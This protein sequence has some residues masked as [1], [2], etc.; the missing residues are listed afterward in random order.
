MII[1]EVDD[2]QIP[3]SLDYFADSIAS[4][5]ILPDGTSCVPP[6]SNPLL[7]NQYMNFVKEG[8]IS[9]SELK[10]E[11]ELN[12]K[13]YLALKQLFESHGEKGEIN[14]DNTKSTIDKNV[15]NDKPETIINN[16]N[17][18]K[19]EIEL[20]NNKK[21]A[22]EISQKPN[23]NIE[24]TNEKEEISK[25]EEINK[26]N[27][28]SKTKENNKSEE[29]SKTEEVCKTNNNLNDNMSSINLDTIIKEDLPVTSLEKDIKEI[30]TNFNIGGSLLS[31]NSI[32]ENDS[33]G[34]Q[35]KRR[36]PLPPV[37]QSKVIDGPDQKT[38][39]K[40]VEV[41]TLPTST[42]VNEE[43]VNVLENQDS[44]QTDKSKEIKSKKNKQDSSISKLLHLPS[45]L[46]FW[47]KS[48]E[49]INKS[50]SYI[51][52]ETAC[53]L[54]IENIDSNLSDLKNSIIEAK[55]IL[56]L[57]KLSTS[58]DSINDAFEDACEIPEND[59][60]ISESGSERKSSGNLSSDSDKT[61]PNTRHEI[62]SSENR[63]EDIQHIPLK[64]DML[65]LHT[66]SKST[67][68]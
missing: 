63:N 50:S 40:S 17:N 28:I 24:N 10:G 56:K 41:I 38:S 33:S 43:N 1:E 14:D 16:E 67:D 19:T 31:L 20:S 37:N 66:E 45:K 39:D 49:N 68:V 27:E 59:N 4:D 44:Q 51:S 26:T 13:K 58:M 61:R 23:E 3:F 52:K 22:T 7:T 34:K 11:I 42:I 15:S 53:S 47:N 6:M 2:R 55:N 46:A 64:L 5:F 36:A 25:T 8:N 29:S 60:V 21:K 30:D 35:K 12:Y 57:Q 54:P 65:V 18:L 32:N 48:D 62:A 9:E